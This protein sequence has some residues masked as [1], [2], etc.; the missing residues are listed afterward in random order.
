MTLSTNTIEISVEINGE[1]YVE[2]VPVRM[3]AADYL[4]HIRG[5]TGTHVGCEQG[6]CG[7]CT[8]EID[9][10]PVKSC[11]MLAV[12]LDG[13]SV[14][15][16]EGMS[17]AGTLSDLQIAFSEKHALQCGFCTPGFLMVARALETRKTMPSRDEI[18]EEISGVICRCT[19]YDGII[20][21]I[22]TH[23]EQHFSHMERAGKR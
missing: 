1:T 2:S 14:R 6:I 12:Q 13:A 7:M 20:N 3:H 22:E 8:V 11:L 17:P 15:T 19:G 10:V 21:A 16:V 4:R 5:L 23:L 9:G 18:A